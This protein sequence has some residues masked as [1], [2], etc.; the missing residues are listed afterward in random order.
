M[1]P[2]TRDLLLRTL[3]LGLACFVCALLCGGCE[4]TKRLTFE[5]EY[6]AVLL[7]NGEAYFGK[8]EG[9]GT[10]FRVLWDVYYVQRQADPKKKEIKN[11][12]LKR[13][14]EWHAPDRMI[15]NADHIVFVEPVGDGSTVAQLIA[16]EKQGSSVSDPR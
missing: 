15:I 5:S 2:V 8:L 9:L 11:I 7:T 14:R 1:K 6:Q 10:A 4:R 13:G 16:K 12:L 3:V